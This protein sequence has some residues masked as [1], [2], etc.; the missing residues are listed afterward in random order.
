MIFLAYLY[1]KLPS[2][3]AI[4]AYVILA[5]GDS[6]EQVWEAWETQGFHLLTWAY[7]EL[8]GGKWP[9][10]VPANT[11]LKPVPLPERN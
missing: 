8:E 7:D 5:N 3:D 1:R 2:S 4:E 6:E 10:P 9:G 11:L